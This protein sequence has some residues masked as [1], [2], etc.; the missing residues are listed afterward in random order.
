[1]LQQGRLEEAE[2]RFL[3]AIRL[4]PKHAAAWNGMARIHAERGDL[5]QSCQAS[6]NA[7]AS[8]PRQAEA[9][10]RLATTLKGRL[11]DDEFQ[12]MQGLIEDEAISV[13]D[14]ALLSIPIRSAS[15]ASTSHISA[16]LFEAFDKHGVAMPSSSVRLQPDV[17]LLE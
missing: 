13:D 15:G 3:E 8:R 1:M 17:K 2:S 5:D 14:R 16:H 10:W 7:I 6:R 4:D 11:P 9:Y 12:A